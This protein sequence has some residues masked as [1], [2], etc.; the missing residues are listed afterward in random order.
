MV[1]N[2]AKSMVDGALEVYWV[3]ME[4]AVDEMDGRLKK[5]VSNE[6]ETRL[7]GYTIVG[8]VAEDSLMSHGE[9][10]PHGGG[11]EVEPTSTTVPN[12][13]GPVIG[14]KLTSHGG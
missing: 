9:I 8:E 3:Q 6:L 11:E 10:Q 5:F 4:K 14:K 7:K 2:T 1:M 13:V 12:Y